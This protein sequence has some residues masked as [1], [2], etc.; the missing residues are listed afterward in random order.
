MAFCT[1]PTTPLWGNSTA[2]KL[3]FPNNL[4]P[5]HRAEVWGLSWFYLQS[6]TDSIS[7]CGLH[8]TWDNPLASGAL[9]AKLCLVNKVVCLDSFCRL[10]SLN[11]NARSEGNEVVC[12]WRVMSANRTAVNYLCPIERTKVP[13]S[14]SVTPYSDLPQVFDTWFRRT[15]N[16]PF[17]LYTTG[18]QYFAIAILCYSV[19]VEKMLKWLFVFISHLQNITSKHVPCEWCWHLTCTSVAQSTK[20]HSSNFIKTRPL[21][22][23]IW[24]QH[25]KRKKLQS[26]A[27]PLRLYLGTAVLWDKC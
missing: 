11:F 12:Q 13:S 5:G 22:I 17:V 27:G 16:S 20:H 1:P 8:W 21:C 24:H 4:Y 14:H 2:V 15:E 3:L 25:E 18:I 19:F 26:T 6:F 7:S 9:N 10:S 23:K